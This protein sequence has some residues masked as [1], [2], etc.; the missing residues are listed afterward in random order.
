MTMKNFKDH[1]SD[2]ETTMI[3]NN[4][5]IKATKILLLIIVL[6]SFTTACKQTVGETLFCEGTTVD[7]TPTTCGT[8]STTG[9]LT[10]I[11]NS[12]TAFTG[13][14]VQ[15]KIYNTDSTSALPEK[16]ITV[17]VTPGQKNVRTEI[18]FYNPGQYRVITED[19]SNKK[20]SEGEIKILDD[21]FL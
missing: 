6:F 1:F 20:I 19:L 4:S 16:T 9:D 15:I 11:V 17:D 12:D 2:K 13:D 18:S 10:L 3:F 8:I 21:I 7:G 14:K 5:T